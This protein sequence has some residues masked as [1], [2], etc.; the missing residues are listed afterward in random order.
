MTN[1]SKCKKYQRTLSFMFNI[2]QV[3][4]NC[5]TDIK[6]LNN[7]IKTPRKARQRGQAARPLR[8]LL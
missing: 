7:H 1:N 6:N 2:D 4:I 3:S 5:R 8:W